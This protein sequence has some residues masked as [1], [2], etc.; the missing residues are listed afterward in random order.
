M[1][2]TA[3]HSVLTFWIARL[4]TS[5]SERMESCKRYRRS[6]ASFARGNAM[7]PA[8]R[9]M[10]ISRPYKSLK[11]KLCHVLRRY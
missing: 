7:T 2:E 6:R 9:D 11:E 10:V 4:Y 1:E 8:L 5:L 3:V